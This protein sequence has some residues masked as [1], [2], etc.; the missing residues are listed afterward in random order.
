MLRKALLL[1]SFLP[2]VACAPAAPA[3]LESDES[4]LESDSKSG[5]SKQ[6][7]SW[8]GEYRLEM[9]DADPFTLSI[10]KSDDGYE[11]KTDLD[12]VHQELSDVDDVLTFECTEKDDAL[13]CEDNA[14]ITKLEFTHLSGGAIYAIWFNQQLNGRKDM[15]WQPKN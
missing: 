9:E 4:N 6:K 11:V 5:S 13:E 10:S 12:R 3:D 7:A 15:T 1:L 8:V 2:L 14:M